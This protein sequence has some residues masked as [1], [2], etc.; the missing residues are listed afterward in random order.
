MPQ[1]AITMVY[2]TLQGSYTNYHHV[3]EPMRRR[4]IEFCLQIGFQT[5]HFDQRYLQIYHLHQALNI[6]QVY[7][8]I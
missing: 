6:S 5:H 7:Y 3:P 2:V 8:Y 4:F 1:C